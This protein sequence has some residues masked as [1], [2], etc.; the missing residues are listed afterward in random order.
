M[1][2]SVTDSAA[3][4]HRDYGV[5]SVV[6]AGAGGKAGGEIQILLCLKLLLP[7]SSLPPSAPTHSS[8]LLPPSL[9]SL[10]SPSQTTVIGLIVGS[11]FYQLGATPGTLRSFFGAAFL[12][13]MFTSMGGVT[14]MQPAVATKG[15]W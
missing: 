9:Y 2:V 13:V 4:T 6:A 1:P 15:V 10:P 12:I 8:P 7:P 5:D 14:Q 11:L 3:D